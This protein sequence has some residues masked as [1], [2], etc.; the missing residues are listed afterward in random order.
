M[1]E[2]GEVEKVGGRKE[3][4]EPP[5]NE[6]QE[7]GVLYLCRAESWFLCNMVLSTDCS[8]R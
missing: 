4:R 3:N 5:G 6:G 2:S 8:G 7:G 1:S